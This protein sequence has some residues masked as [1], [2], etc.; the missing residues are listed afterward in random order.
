MKYKTRTYTAVDNNSS[1]TS[2]FH[3]EKDLAAIQKQL[4]F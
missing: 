4:S 1:S 3:E 2:N